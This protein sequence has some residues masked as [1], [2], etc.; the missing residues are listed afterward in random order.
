M[1][2]L[3]HNLKNVVHVVGEG[4]MGVVGG[5]RFIIM[6]FNTKTVIRSKL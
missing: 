2:V 5:A 6:L 1:Q 4:G 3:S